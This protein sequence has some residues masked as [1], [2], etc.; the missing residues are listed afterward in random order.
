MT[1]MKVTCHSLS[2]VVRFP[3]PTPRRWVGGPMSRKGGNETVLGSAHFRCSSL[4]ECDTYL[5]F[6][7]SKDSIGAAEFGFGQPC[8]AQGQFESRQGEKM[9]PW[10]H[11]GDNLAH[12]GDNLATTWRHPGDTLA[13]PWRHPGDTLA[14]SLRLT[15]KEEGGENANHLLSR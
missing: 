15:A 6:C 1:F 8:T 2:D 5:E 11:P 14:T 9:S 13:T 7:M 12:P 4:G 10:L 3:R